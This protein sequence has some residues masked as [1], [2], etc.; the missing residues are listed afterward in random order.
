MTT[1]V[2]NPGN[3]S[4]SGSGMT[5]I[6]GII[7]LVAVVFLFLYFGLPLLR[8]AAGGGTTGGV[9][10]NLPDKIDVNVQNPTQGQ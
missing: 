4:D 2:N 3:G 5:M 6:V 8:N 1:V 9:Q 10:I 7:L